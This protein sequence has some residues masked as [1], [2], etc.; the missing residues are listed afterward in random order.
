MTG[1]TSC[2][3]THHGGCSF[4][5]AEMA[6]PLAPLSLFVAFVF[7]RFYFLFYGVFYFSD[8]FL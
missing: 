5:M 6:P 8:F 1:K 2:G 4:D 3:T 7:F